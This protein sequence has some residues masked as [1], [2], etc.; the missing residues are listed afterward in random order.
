VVSGAIFDIRRYSLH[1]G[2]GIRTA[3]FFKGCPLVCLWCHNPEGQA[4]GPELVYREGRC[5]RCGACVAECRNGAVEAREGQIVTDREKC[6]RC[7]R[8][9]EACCTGAR[10]FAG[11]EATVSEVMAEV[12]RDIPFYEESGG[13]VTFTGGEPLLQREF[14]LHLLRESRRKGIRTAVET[15]GY[16]PWE[17]LEEVRGLVDLFLYDVK[18]MDE[19]RH[20]RFSGVSNRPILENLRDLSR[21]G[22]EIVL[23][24]PVIPGVNDDEEN[25]RR[26]AELAASLPRLMRVDLLPY[27][28]GGAR[29]YEG[30]SRSYLLGGIRTPSE[31]RMAALAA[32]VGSYGLQVR[33]GG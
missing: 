21:L 24:V 3:V 12:E 5:I 1:D 11:R 28:Q 16:A 30:M 19:E 27:H 7:G 25:V 14:L 4:C 33:V 17:A 32:A 18:I 20:R 6:L 31:E 2:P 29:K 22:H 13:G 8:C 26:T 15:C 9:L 23:R 10:E